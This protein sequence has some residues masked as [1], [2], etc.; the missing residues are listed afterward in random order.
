LV[1]E[2]RRWAYEGVDEPV[3]YQGQLQ[4]YWADA[5]GRPA[6]E[7]IDGARFIPLTVKWYSDNLLMFL[8]KARRPEFRDKGTVE[9]SGP[10]GGPMQMQHQGKVDIHAHIKQ[11]AGEFL[12]AAQHQLREVLCLPFGRH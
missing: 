7:G 2:V 1:D 11:Y 6:K 4:V 3:I 5:E 9:L 8:V 12:A 10:A